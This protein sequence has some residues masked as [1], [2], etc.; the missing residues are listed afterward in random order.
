MTKEQKLDLI[1]AKRSPLEN[2]QFAAELDLKLA[3]ED[4]AEELIA[5]PKE[6]LE[7]I[8]A[9]LKLLDNEEAAIE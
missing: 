8:N 9:K 7:K 6:R 5:E 1:H 4:G 2:E 3:N